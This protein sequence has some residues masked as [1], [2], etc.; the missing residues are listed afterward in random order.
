MFEVIK[1]HEFQEFQESM[2]FLEI[3]LREVFK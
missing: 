2:E 3:D 1:N